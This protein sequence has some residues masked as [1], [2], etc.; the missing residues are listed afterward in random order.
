[1]AEY[2]PN[3][4][5]ALNGIFCI[6]KP[7]GR[8]VFDIVHAL[9][10][11]LARELNQMPG[12]PLREKVVISNTLCSDNLPTITTVPDVADHPLVVGLRYIKDDF[13][14]GSV[15][16]LGKHASG[17]LVMGIGNGLSKLRDLAT[18]GFLRVYHVKGQLGMA[19]HN[20]SP[21]GRIIERTTYHH[22]T[23]PRMDRV[24]AAVQ[25]GHQKHM[26]VTAGVDIQSQEAYELAV[27]GLIRPTDLKAGAVIYGIRCIEFHPP[28]FTIEVHAVNETCTYLMKLIHEIG[29][30]L[31]A[32]AV[33][34]QV[35]RIRYGHFR[36]NHAL[37]TKHCTSS[38]LI[39]NIEFCHELVSESKLNNRPALLVGGNDCLDPNLY[40]ESG[41][42]TH[43]F[44]D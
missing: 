32:S 16:Q 23:R 1:M 18:A 11:N 6:Y 35:R 4:F 30:E 22:I 33:C 12:R 43:E 40:I 31:R 8:T 36:L 15:G 9:K 26:F 28:D 21:V 5:R 7:V 20:F 38:S 17:V 19:T 41:Q 3:V 44:S 29:L 27:G 2:A 14:I 24:L 37:L 39:Q 42:F 10:T 34:S 25:A 13:R